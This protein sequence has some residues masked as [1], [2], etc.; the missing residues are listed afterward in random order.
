VF[1]LRDL[2]FSKPHLSTSEKKRLFKAMDWAFRVGEFADTKAIAD[3]F[4]ISTKTVFRYY[5]EARA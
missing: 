3:R 2:D 1:G 5:K 4:G